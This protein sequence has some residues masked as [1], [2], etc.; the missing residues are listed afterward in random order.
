MGREGEGEG[1][2]KVLEGERMR[3]RGSKGSKETNRKSSYSREDV[4]GKDLN[5]ELGLKY[6]KV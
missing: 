6:I 1:E 2:G 4:P 3:R 5:V